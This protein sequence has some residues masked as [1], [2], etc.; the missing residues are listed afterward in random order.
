[1]EKVGSGNLS[2]EFK[3]EER[4]DEIGKLSNSFAKMIS[5]LNGLIMSVKHASDVTIDASSNVSAKIQET[6]ASIQ[7][8]NAI[9]DVIKKRVSQGKIVKEGE[10]QVALTKDEVIRQKTR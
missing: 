1:M 7:Q 8:T 6:Y 2:I 10:R 5:N 9:L 4:K 3:V